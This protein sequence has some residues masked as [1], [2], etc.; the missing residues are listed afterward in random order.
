MKLTREAVAKCL[1]LPLNTLDR[2]VR[3]GL[4][5]I[6]L[7]GEGFEFKEPAL[8]KWAASHHLAFRPP[9]AASAQPQETL[10]EDLQPVM[11]RGG[12]F[13]GVRGEDVSGVL[14][15]AVDVIPC[16]EADRRTQL[17]TRLLER[18]ALT[19]TGIGRGVAIPHPRAPLDDSL[20]APS[21]TTCFL[22]KPV[23][24]HSVD[25]RPVFVLFV[26]LSTS[27]KVHLHLLSRLSF[28]VRSAAFIEFLRHTPEP[29]T[30]LARVTEFEAR[31]DSGYNR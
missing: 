30:L 27:V 4:I 14:K 11:A 16:I 17:F 31:L 20:P 6:H 29:D 15:S 25:D 3:Q 18:E 23:D 24:F 22:E 19:S 9:A 7:N 12:I 5:P 26:L 13:Y 8:R 2:W 28:G 1:D 10:L 21:I